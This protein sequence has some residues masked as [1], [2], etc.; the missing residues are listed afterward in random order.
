MNF[1]ISLIDKKAK[2]YIGIDCS[3]PIYQFG[4]LIVIG[5]FTLLL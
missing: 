1:R 3:E 4:E 2:I 5:A